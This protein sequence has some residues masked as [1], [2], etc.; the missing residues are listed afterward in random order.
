MKAKESESH[1]ASYFLT[2]AVVKRSVTNMSHQFFTML[3]LEMLQ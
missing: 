2:E 1:T 3:S